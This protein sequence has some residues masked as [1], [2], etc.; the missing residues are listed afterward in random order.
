MF[1]ILLLTSLTVH[2]Q[3]RDRFA[4]CNERGDF[5]EPQIKNAISILAPR[6]LVD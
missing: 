2:E 4:E 6:E 3:L 5:D 1:Y